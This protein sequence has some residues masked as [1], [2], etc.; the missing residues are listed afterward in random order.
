MTRSGSRHGFLAMLLV[1]LAA[2]RPARAD[3]GVVDVAPAAD[4]ADQEPEEHT[5][6]GSAGFRIVAG[7]SRAYPD[8]TWVFGFGATGE[9][10]LGLGFEVG[11]GA[12]VLL[13]ESSEVFPLE[14][15]LKKSFT[16]APDVDFHLQ[17]GPVLAIVNEP[18]HEVLFLGGA[19]FASGFTLWQSGGFGILVE[20]TYQLV[21]EE[22]LVHDI[23]GAVGVVTRF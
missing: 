18:G 21:A 12:A 9:L 20:A 3:E 5:H 7:T 13:G 10:H 17:A 23:E 6:V 22:S 15:F 19:T 16:L 8:N 14:L 11:I 4:E 2:P 1:V